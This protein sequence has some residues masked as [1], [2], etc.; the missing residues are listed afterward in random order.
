MSD[1]DRIDPQTDILLVLLRE[2]RQTAW[3]IVEAT[4]W[5][6]KAVN[7]QLMLFLRPW[8]GTEK[9]VHVDKSAKPAPRWSLTKKGVA[10]ALQ[11]DANLSVRAANIMRRR[12]KAR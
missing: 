7:R 12:M 3:E 6:V 2:E 5:G 1:D 4:G 9:L 11:R 8:E 10:V